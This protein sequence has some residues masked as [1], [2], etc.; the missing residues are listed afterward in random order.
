MKILA[1]SPLTFKSKNGVYEWYNQS[2]LWD[3]VPVQRSSIRP[4]GR[5]S[6][7]DL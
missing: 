4:R 6:G 1:F 7:G 2:Q 5:P 3:D